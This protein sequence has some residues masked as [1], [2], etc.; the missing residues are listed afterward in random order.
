MNT[1]RGFLVNRL[2]DAANVICI[3]ADKLS[4]QDDSIWRE[5]MWAEREAAHLIDDVEAAI[6]GDETGLTDCGVFA[7]T[8]QDYVCRCTVDGI[9]PQCPIHKH[10]MDISESDRAYIDR[11][12]D[13]DMS[14]WID[15]GSEK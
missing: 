3:A 14:T 10:G 6:R 7:T 11:E 15:D 5:R 12:Q 9:E 2:Y 4:P 13:G 1:L 8:P